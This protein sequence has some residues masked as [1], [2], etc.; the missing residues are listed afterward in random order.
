M[1]PLNAI[2]DVSQDKQLRLPRIPEKINEWRDVL[3]VRFKVLP[4]A[5]N[6]K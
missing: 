6:L 5:P 4:V 2:D 3:G 1:L